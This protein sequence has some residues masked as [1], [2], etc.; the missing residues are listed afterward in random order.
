VRLA[1]APLAA[2]AGRGSEP[3]REQGMGISPAERELR[4]T[5]R[6]LRRNRPLVAVVVR[7][8]LEDEI[9]ELL[10]WI[11]FLRWAQTGSIGLRER[12]F[13]VSRPSSAVWY[14]GIGAKHAELD[15]PGSPKLLEELVL[16]AFGLGRGEFR[17]LSPDPVLAARPVLAAQDPARRLQHRLLEFSLL[18]APEPPPN[19]ELPADYLAICFDTD[20][21]ELA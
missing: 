1:L 12:L 19:L 3:H 18:A 14:E 8:W 20:E 16:R 10:Y 9:G 11:P 17:V 13:V 6:R 5:I 4:Q 21:A 15:G 7:P 2:L